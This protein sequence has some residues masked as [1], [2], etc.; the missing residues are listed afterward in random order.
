[1]YVC[2]CGGLGGGGGVG[3]TKTKEF[4][5]KSIQI[6]TF[7]VYWLSTAFTRNRCENRHYRILVTNTTNFI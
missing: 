7:L 1:M 5:F 6:S 3:L 2:M 4:E